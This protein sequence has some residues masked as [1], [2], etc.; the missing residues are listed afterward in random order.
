MTN[1]TLAQPSAWRLA[2][3][4]I[5]RSTAWSRV[6]WRPHRRALFATFGCDHTVTSALRGPV[7]AGLCCGCLSVSRR[8]G[9]WHE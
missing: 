5:E 4:L 1:N 9:A 2:L 8:V 6:A 7:F 3:D